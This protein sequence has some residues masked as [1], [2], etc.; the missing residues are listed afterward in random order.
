MRYVF[1]PPWNW[2]KNQILQ[3]RKNNTRTNAKNRVRVPQSTHILA[4][5]PPPNPYKTDVLQSLQHD[6]IW[7]KHITNFG[8]YISREAKV[9]LRLVQSW[10]KS[11]VR[12][13]LLHGRGPS[14]NSGKACTKCL[15]TARSLAGLPNQW[16]GNTISSQ[17]LSPSPPAWSILAVRSLCG[18]LWHGSQESALV[19][20]VFR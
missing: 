14:C 9:G 16:A 19:K 12:R 18:Q 10:S 1:K 2:P 5:L 15:Q 20:Q 4:A 17:S 8:N 3:H 6:S 13:T 11:L 7:R